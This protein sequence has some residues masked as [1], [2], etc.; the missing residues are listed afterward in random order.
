MLSVKEEHVD[1]LTAVVSGIVEGT[2]PSLLELPFDA[3][4]N[5]LTQL[6]CYVNV[7]I[8]E[9]NTLAKFASSISRGDLDCESPRGGMHALHS[10]KNLHANLRHLTWKT[11]QIARGDFSQRVDF[12]GDF[13]KS[14][15][16][17]VEQLASARQELLRKNDELDT[18]SRTDPLTGLL[19]RRG[20]GEII[21]RELH[22]AKRTKRPFV[23]CMADI[24]HFK[25]INDTHGHDAGDAVLVNVAQALMKQVRQED[26][27]A[28]WGGEEFLIL[29]TE[30]ELLPAL[31]AGERLRLAV[32]AGATP[33]N[34]IDVQAT[35][36]AGM[37]VYNDGEDIDSC[38][39]R[40]DLCLYKAK[41]GGRN[42]IWFQES[43]DTPARPTHG[44]T[45]GFSGNSPAP[46]IV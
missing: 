17:M 24:D 14:F 4:V 46:P 12:M 42:Q 44:A 45:A 33:C 25:K 20:A 34:G 37:S 38:V 2:T 27:C 32:E 9:Y 41:E 1:R 39:R 30:T 10:L 43:P 3:S 6:A 29:L 11:E 36:S 19:N 15:N 8:A 21:D 16:S 18:V 22:R 35:I 31:A 26:L 5:E 40:S 7:L 28:R 23:I 13:S